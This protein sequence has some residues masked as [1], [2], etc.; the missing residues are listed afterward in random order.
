MENERIAVVA[1]LREGRVVLALPDDEAEKPDG[2]TF[3]RVGGKCGIPPRSPTERV[4]E[5]RNA[6]Q[7]Q[8]SPQ[9][10]SVEISAVISILK[11]SGLFDSWRYKT[12]LGG[13][14]LALCGGISIGQRRILS[15]PYRHHRERRW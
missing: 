2:S 8:D 6:T 9:S 15:K 7:R 14:S 3:A 1:Q 11:D 12:A 5:S 4:S 10:W 13:L